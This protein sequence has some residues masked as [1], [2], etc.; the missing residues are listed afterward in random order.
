MVNSVNG[1]MYTSGDYSSYD[2][3]YYANEAASDTS[4]SVFSGLVGTAAVATIATVT[5]I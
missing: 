3:I 4:G 2:D 5:T 1:T